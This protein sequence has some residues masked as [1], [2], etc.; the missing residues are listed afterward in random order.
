MVSIPLLH[1][2]CHSQAIV[3]ATALNLNLNHI[4]IAL[5]SRG[6]SE[7]HLHRVPVLPVERTHARGTR[8][9]PPFLNPLTITLL[10]RF[11]VLVLVMM[12]VLAREIVSDLF[13]NSPLRSITW[14]RA[15]ELYR[16]LGPESVETMKAGIK[17]RLIAEFEGLVYLAV[18]V[19]PKKQ[20]GGEL[21]AHG[22]QYL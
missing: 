17:Q 1:I 10:W 5:E 9:L 18:G 2:H 19:Q 6:I 7:Q 21:G 14:Y 11:L 13:G 22:E 15:L 3:V 16:Q 4:A 12:A 20:S 8:S